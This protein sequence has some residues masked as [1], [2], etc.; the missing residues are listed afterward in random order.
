MRDQ[1]ERQKSTC[2]LATSGGT[3]FIALDAFAR[4]AKGHASGAGVPGCHDL[5]TPQ[6]SRRIL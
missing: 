1:H 4:T 3:L 6:H 2:H 5:G